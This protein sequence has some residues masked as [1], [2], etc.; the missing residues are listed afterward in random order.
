MSKDDFNGCLSNAMPKRYKLVRIADD[1]AVAHH[2]D[3]SNTELFE[4][5]IKRISGKQAA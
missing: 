5:S 2:S 4:Q 3:V 1:Q